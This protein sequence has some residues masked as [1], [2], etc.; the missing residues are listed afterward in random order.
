[1]SYDRLAIVDR[2]DSLRCP[3][4]AVL[5]LRGDCLYHSAPNQTDRRATHA[6]SADC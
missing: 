5:A 2:V 4:P 3:Q 6:T 1:M